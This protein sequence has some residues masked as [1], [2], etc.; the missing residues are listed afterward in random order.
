MRGLP[1][2]PVQVSQRLTPVGKAEDYY[3]AG[4]LQYT[5]YVCVYSFKRRLT[6][7]VVLLSIFAGLEGLFVM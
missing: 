4:E 5:R 1:S 3:V 2:F 7:W 6:V